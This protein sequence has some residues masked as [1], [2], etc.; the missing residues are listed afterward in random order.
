M[1][2]EIILLIILIF[3]LYTEVQNKSLYTFLFGN[4]GLG[5]HMW[6]HADITLPYA[7]SEKHNHRICMVIEA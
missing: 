1:Y 7:R 4:S 5:T 6:E 2:L 3:R